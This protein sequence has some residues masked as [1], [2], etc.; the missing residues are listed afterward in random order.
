[1]SDFFDKIES[2]NP[3]LLAYVEAEMQ[4][5]DVKFGKDF[6]IVVTAALTS[7]LGGK[8]LGSAGSVT[9]AQ[10]IKWN[11]SINLYSN[12]A[13]LAT[14]AA[15]EA[16]MSVG[17][18]IQL[19]VGVT[20]QTATEIGITALS[21]SVGAELIAVAAAGL[22]IPALINETFEGI[23]D[24]NAV[25]TAE[26]NN[27]YL[28]ECASDQTEFLEENWDLVKQFHENDRDWS[29]KKKDDTEWP[30]LTFSKNQSGEPPLSLETSHSS[31]P[32]PE[33]FR[34]L[35][36]KIGTDFNFTRQGHPTDLINNYVSK[37]LEQ[38]IQAAETQKG[39]FAMEH[40]SPFTPDIEAAGDYGKIKLDELSEKYKTDRARFLFYNL[41]PG[42]VVFDGTS[43]I[44]FEDWELKKTGEG[45]E[46][47][48]QAT[49]I[50]NIH[51]T[52]AEHIRKYIF[53]SSGD[54]TNIEGFFY[55]DHLYGMGGEDTI[56]GHDGN[57]YIEGGKGHDILHGDGGNDTFFVMGKDDAYDDFYG[58][59]DT[60]TIQGS[61]NPAG[62]VIRVH[63]FNYAA[64]S[65]ENIKGGEGEDSISGT[66]EGDTID[67]TG[68]NL[69][70]IERIEGG[71]GGD[72][73]RGT[74]GA[75]TI[76][77]GSFEQV[78]D[79]ERDV[80]DG[81][82]GANTYHIGAGDTI[83]DED[84]TGTIWFNGQKLSALTLTQ[85][86]EDQD[87][88]ISADGSLRALHNPADST[89][90]ITAANGKGYFSI[91]GYA[92]GDFGIS[93]EEYS[94][95]ETSNDFTI[96]GKSSRNEMSVDW[97]WGPNV[98]DYHLT[99]T[100]FPNSDPQEP[101]F[102]VE[103]PDSA[104]SLSVTGGQSG[105]HLF[106]FIAADEIRGGA[107]N[108]IITGTLFAQDGKELYIS[109]T[110][111]GDLLKGEGGNDWITGGGGADTI[112]GGTGNDV[113]NGLDGEDILFGGDGDDL[114]AGAKHN[115]TL[116]G[117]TGD[118]ILLGAGYTY[119][120]GA[121]SLTLDNLD[122]FTFNLTY[123]TDNGQRLFPLSYHTSNF[124]TA[125]IAEDPGQNSL[126]GGDGNDFLRGGA[127]QDFLYGEADHDSLTG[128][129]GADYLF[130]GDGQ[131]NLIG[132]NGDCVET[133]T[134]GG[135]FLS[136]G[137][138]SDYLNGLGGDDIL[139]GDEDADQLFGGS[140]A[141]QLYGGSGVDTLVGEGGDDL[142]HG[143]EDTDYLYGDNGDATG[144]GSD[145]LYGEGGDDHLYGH[146]GIDTLYGGSGNDELQGNGENDFLY[147]G[148]GDDDLFGQDGNDYLEGGKGVDYLEG[149]AGNNTYYF[150]PGNSG[151]NGDTINCSSGSHRI[152]LDVGSLSNMVAGVSEDGSTMTLWYTP[153]DVIMFANFADGA[154]VSFEVG[155]QGYTWAEFHSH[156][157]NAITG[158]DGD[159][160]LVGGGAA[161]IIKGGGGKD[162]LSGN[163]GNDSLL[164]GDGDDILYG[165]DGQDSLEGGTGKDY[166]YGGESDDTYVFTS[167]HGTDF[168]FDATGQSTISLD[169]NRDESL[170]HLKYATERNGAIYEEKDGNGVLIRY[171]GGS[172]FVDNGRNNQ[173]WS[174]QFTDSVMYNAE[175]LQSVEVEQI[176]G[177]G[178]DSLVGQLGND[179]LEGAGGN[180]VLIGGVG[181]DVLKG[182]AGDDYIEGGSGADRMDG[183]S[184]VD[185]LSYRHDT[186]GVVVDLGGS[187][188]GGE[189]QGDTI[190]GFENVIG[191]S[192]DDVLTG[193]SYNNVLE[194]GGG[195][196]RLNGGGGFDTAD[197]SSSKEAVTVDLINGYGA[198]G[199]AEG[200]TYVGIES[201]I[202]SEF[203]DHLIGPGANAGWESSLSGLGGDDVL[204]GTEKFGDI[205]DGGVGNDTLKGGGQG[206]IYL[207]KRGYGQDTIQDVD[208]YYESI[209]TT[210]RWGHILLE[211][212]WVQESY[213]TNVL[214]FSDD[215]STSDVSLYRV[216]AVTGSGIGPDDLIIALKD[217]ENPD[218]SW[219]D[220]DDRIVISGY[221]THSVFAEVNIFEESSVWG[222]PRDSLLPSKYYQEYQ[223]AIE[224]FEFSDQTL[225]DEELIALQSVATSG[226]DRL[227]VHQYNVGNTDVSWD[228][229]EG[230]DTLIG[231]SGDDLLIGGAGNDQLDGRG[232]INQLKGG[233]GNDTYIISNR[234]IFTDI[235]PDAYADSIPPPQ[236][237]VQD[238]VTDESG[239]DKVV[240]QSDIAREDIVFTLNDRDELVVDYGL[241]QQHQLVILDDTVESFETS[242]G[243]T[244][245]RDAI[246]AA[247]DQIAVLAGKPVEEMSNEDIVNNLNL[248]SILYNSWT[249]KFVVYNGYDDWNDFA[250]N[251][252][253]EIVHGGAGTDSI[254]GHSGND[255]L[256]G[257]GGDDVLNGGNGNDT[258]LFRAGDG[259]D[260]V[261]DH[262]PTLM[263]DSYGSFEEYS[264]TGQYDYLATWQNLFEVKP[265]A[266]PNDD[267]L[268]LEGG[269]SSDNIVLSWEIGEADPGS[270]I[271][272]LR[273]GIKGTEDSVTIK[274]FF[275]PEK[276]VEHIRFDNGEE[277]SKSQI[278]GLLATNEADAIRGFRNEQ[279]VIDGLGG[280]DILVGAGQDD[281]LSGSG[282]KDV[283]YGNAGN[284]ILR[285][286]ADN[287]L[288]FGGLG[289]DIYELSEGDDV[290]DDGEGSNTLQLTSSENSMRFV[291]Y[292]GDSTEADPLGDDLLIEYENGSTVVKNFRNVTGYSCILSDGTIL[293]HAAVLQLIEEQSVNKPPVI[294][295]IDD[296]ETELGR[297][298]N[299]SIAPQDI[300]DPDAGQTESLNISAALQDGSQL[301]DWLSFN[302]V[303]LTFSG[304][305]L[306]EQFLSVVLRVEDIDGAVTLEDFSLKVTRPEPTLSGSEVAD[307]LGGTSESDAI[308]GYD[309]A[310]YLFGHGGDDHLIGGDGNDYL[311]GGSGADVMEGG[312]GGD[313]YEVDDV[314]DVVIEGEQGG[315]DQVRSSISYT[316]G[317]SL[318]DLRLTG[319]TSLNGIGNTL[320]N[321]I[322]GNESANTLSGLGGADYLFGHGGDDH[323]IG[324]GGNDYL[325][326][327]GGDDTLN[328]GDGNDYMVGGA[329]S[330][331]FE[332]DIRNSTGS[333]FSRIGDFTADE[334]KLL[335]HTEAGSSLLG[336]TQFDTNF[337]A[338]SAGV[339]LDENDFLI[340]NTS[341]GSLFYDADGSG[342]GAAVEIASLI[343][344]AELKSTDFIVSS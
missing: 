85:V 212:R 249:D 92:S 84:K 310:D 197:Y 25:F 324:G 145:T 290:I 262:D 200:D 282:G 217:P 54:D 191:G 214:R 309:G 241:Y 60:D 45:Y 235:S 294:I 304:Q 260:L 169:V 156:V 109:D 136:G 301:P 233:A 318:E 239:N 68:V 76:Y 165:G 158:G 291:R 312:I 288:M 255:T 73:I 195:A 137:Q 210:D 78:E 157:L 254:R 116:I 168:I 236:R 56:H 184:G 205:L 247:L 77:G 160:T 343:N 147:G 296:H 234:N 113:L 269:I 172:I 258:Y 336:L 341:S 317:T 187:A 31:Y 123:H 344:K 128:G 208:G 329:G 161:D 267:T 107:G 230:D 89:L 261:Y 64:N 251:S 271:G 91:A 179:T 81:G 1:M 140:G 265:S 245:S 213:G 115:A 303:T 248:K 36:E 151:G 125:D 138:G 276:S 218:A 281:E 186:T 16:D 202:G 266:A 183:G 319:T 146:G 22:A 155:G 30:I 79:Y 221:F 159:D 173:D 240:F 67:L 94:S 246:I 40:L 97:M 209:D 95:P 211:S 277:L 110:V 55:D 253:N 229:G 52:P 17:D 135:D 274:D 297:L 219:Q 314:G 268:M 334:D 295:P 311:I 131:D 285:G 150:A 75:D 21:L 321:S 315:K 174:I 61:D 111:A 7:V 42:E 11:G 143:G 320:D 142:L 273:I 63:D 280:D 164:G 242:D 306:S 3:E 259:N 59:D 178:D 293:D 206:D 9:L 181:D 337:I 5:Q 292:L 103:L 323:L 204:V 188:S 74:S 313:Y 154:N 223:Y 308:Y 39:M 87:Q 100:S 129:G 34:T 228:A 90:E 176:G 166:L 46:D 278:L 203:D 86:F 66:E 250:G 189:A 149:G 38:L 207:Y 199:D 72:T 237:V 134:D 139:S 82:A 48:W 163:A 263:T 126:F 132:D 307:S 238:V 98:T 20:A 101:F 225:W 342:Q 232:G 252:Q 26:K 93:L 162:T 287:D 300:F 316:L 231:G 112:D 177:D 33:L 201:I 222:T 284:D 215:I 117:G 121:T 279:N 298:F 41:H 43:T 196:D 96:T 286:G 105:D 118:D 99:C 28:V 220:L 305:P 302:P 15:M 270:A 49:A 24:K 71:S 19:L 333:G 243:S 153:T 12:G 170:L 326:G 331:I 127:D 335:L 175:I 198:G 37:S 70:S 108:D 226:N 29:L 4:K 264:E 6:A 10:E 257:G 167:G 144:S 62:D 53:G 102:D 152:Q 114:L 124:L 106:G 289:D 327:E 130:G 283:L 171:V 332:I 50:R 51:T 119:G 69:D 185:T 18:A 47:Q 13:S 256:A 133:S 322:V 27:L 57:D 275:D 65:I 325:Y 44:L 120:S 104:P 299:L 272:D 2:E 227:E 83:Y 192:G 339:A 58:G 194:G 88:Y 32:L 340:Y 14:S 8:M 23:Y 122:Q 35:L 328:G 224:K 141:D 180:D 190:T 193:T 244:I 338:S 216:E 148:S 330:D 80:L 182:G